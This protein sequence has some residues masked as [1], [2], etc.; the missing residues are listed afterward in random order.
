[1]SVIVE[2]EF[3]RQVGPIGLEVAWPVEDDAAHAAWVEE[4]LAV[5][6]SWWWHVEGGPWPDRQVTRLTSD[7][8]RDLLE[9][10]RR[11]DDDDHGRLVLVV[12]TREAVAPL[13]G[14]ATAVRRDVLAFCAGASPWLMV[15]VRHVDMNNFYAFVPQPPPPELAAWIARWPRARRCR[16]RSYAGLH[17]AQLEKWNAP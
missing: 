1:M 3:R 7:S 15:F 6:V 16:V 11:W 12:A 2:Q 5:G 9:E 10:L 14:D 17:L 8:G 13:L 4:M